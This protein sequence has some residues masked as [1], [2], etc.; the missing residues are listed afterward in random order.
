[1]LINMIRVERIV[2]LCDDG[3]HR[4]TPQAVPISVKDKVSLER[5]RSNL[6]KLY[7]TNVVRFEY[8]EEEEEV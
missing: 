1:M 6:K 7:A 2:V 5:L 4:V 3:K 8:E